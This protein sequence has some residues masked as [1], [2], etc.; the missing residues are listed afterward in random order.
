MSGGVPYNLSVYQ[1]ETYTFSVQW[2]GAN[3]TGATA[4]LQIR[5]GVYDDGGAALDALSLGSGITFTTSAGATNPDTANVTITAV[6]SAGWT[7]WTSGHYDLTVTLADGVTKK[8][9]AQGFVQITKR[10]S[11]P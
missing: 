6:R 8:A 5:A 9:L 10:I 7:L 3:L 11:G 1:G 4:L 2:T